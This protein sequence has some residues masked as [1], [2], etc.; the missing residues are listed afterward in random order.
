MHWTLCR[1][2][3][4]RAIGGLNWVQVGPFDPDLVAAL[5]G[6]MSAAGRDVYALLGVAS[7]VT[8]VSPRG[9]EP[10]AVR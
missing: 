9:R 7:L 4:R 6:P 10:G 5:F 3:C 2:V 8:L 1:C